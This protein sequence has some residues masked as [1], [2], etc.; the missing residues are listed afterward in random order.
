MCACVCM[1]VCVVRAC[2]RMHLF[3]HVCM[4]GLLARA[5][6]IYDPRIHDPTSSVSLL[7]VHIKRSQRVY[8]AVDGHQP[9][10]G[11]SPRLCVL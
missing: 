2:M 6:V 9:F 10:D 3:A 11:W 4:S 7:P 5:C 8:D 1:S